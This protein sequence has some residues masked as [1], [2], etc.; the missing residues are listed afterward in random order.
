MSADARARIRNYVA[1]LDE[2]RATLA[3]EVEDDV[4]RVRG[5]SL[6]ARGDLVA[7]VCRSAWAILRSRADVTAVVARRE[8]P[9][10]D[11]AQKWAV[12][13]NRGRAAR[14]GAPRG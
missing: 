3:R 13:M 10:R 14:T 1:R 11:F 4:A 7:R 9:A 5:L 8:E 12:L 6:E 2:R